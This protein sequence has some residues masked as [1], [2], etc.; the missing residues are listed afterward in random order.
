MLVVVAVV[1]VVVVVV[2]IV[3]RVVIV[4]GIVDLFSVV[5][6]GPF[7]W[8]PSAVQIWPFVVTITLIIV[9]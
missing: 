5:L 9:I 6:R 4:A 1:V 7:S 8:L 2:V 3:V